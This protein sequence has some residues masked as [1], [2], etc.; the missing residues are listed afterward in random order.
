MSSLF[1]L[2]FRGVLA[3]EG[4]SAVTAAMGVGVFDFEACFVEGVD[5][6]E[7]AAFDVGD[8]GF[9]HDEGDA[10]VVDGDVIFV[11]SVVEGEVVE[12]S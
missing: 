3:A 4:F 11:F 1:F 5:V 2:F 12:E 10:V 7:G 6:V 9:V 8:D